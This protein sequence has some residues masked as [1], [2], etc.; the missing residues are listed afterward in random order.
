MRRPGFTAGLLLL[1]VI[2]VA[3]GSGDSEPSTEAA[4]TSTSAVET[5]PSAEGGGE[6]DRAPDSD[7]LWPDVL[8]ATIKATGPGIYSVSATLSSP[9]DSPE[10]YA[11]GWRVVGPDGTVYGERPLAHDHA[12]EQP[13]TRS[14]SGVAIPAGVAEVTIEGRDQVS[15]WGGDTVTIAVPTSGS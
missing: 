12:G 2:G 10:R 1:A 4:P 5:E 8:A 14:V 13:F 3:C 15:G 6:A 11:D 7:D 9:Y